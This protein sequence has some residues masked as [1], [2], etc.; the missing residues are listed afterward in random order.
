MYLQ[1]FIV[2]VVL[3][4]PSLISYLAAPAVST[5]TVILDIAS[6]LET[7]E[8]VCLLP[9]D[10]VAIQTHSASPIFVPKTNA[11]VSQ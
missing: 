2:L 8:F 7:S 5:L 10:T 4:T 6:A 1:V 9:Q 3:T 11:L